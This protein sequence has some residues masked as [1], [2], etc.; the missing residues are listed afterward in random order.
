[1]YLVTDAL[2]KV[3]SVSVDSEKLVRY[4]LPVPHGGHNK[5]T[6]AAPIG[7]STLGNGAQRVWCG[8]LILLHLLTLHSLT[9]LTPSS[10]IHQ[11]QIYLNTT[12]MKNLWIFNENRL[13][14][15]H[16]LYT[17]ESDPCG[18]DLVRTLKIPKN[19]LSYHV[20]M[21]RD[22]GIIEEKRCGQKKEYHIAK[23]QKKFVK[24]VLSIVELT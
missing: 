14:I 13:R 10:I 15:L 18:C 12:T 2:S 19:L 24:S 22:E 6:S 17:C 9:L 5:R 3:I 20:K 16:T 8:W 7:S 23:D 21:L 11:V 4:Y 1:M